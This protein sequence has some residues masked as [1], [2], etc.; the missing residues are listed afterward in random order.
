[1]TLAVYLAIYSSLAHT[2]ANSAFKSIDL[3]PNWVMSWIGARMESRVDD[4]SAIQQQSS[5]YMST[6]AYSSGRGNTGQSDAERIA[7]ANAAK[8]K[9]NNQQQPPAPINT[10]GQKKQAP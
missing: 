8:T 2:L 10:T 9:L 5:Q 7:A 6:M 3:M 1:M 4:V